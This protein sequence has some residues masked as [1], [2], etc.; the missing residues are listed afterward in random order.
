MIL[1]SLFLMV[2]WTFAQTT[3]NGVVLS[4]DGNEPVI[5]ATVQVVGANNVGT[6]TDVDGQF[7]ITCPE[8]KNVIRISYLGMQPIE[9]IGR[10]NLRI[11]L[12]D[13]SNDLDE[14]IVYRCCRNNQYRG[15]GRCAYS[16]P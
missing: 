8:G 3:V 4:E 16:E 6:V 14:I 12:R 7:T 15:I 1:A 2:G 10:Q 5:G 11:V 13:D 9:V